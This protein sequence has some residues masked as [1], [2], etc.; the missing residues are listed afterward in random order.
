MTDP[1][2][3]AAD[4]GLDADDFAHMREITD[5]LREDQRFGAE[6]AHNTRDI[7]VNAKDLERHRRKLLAATGNYGT[8]DLEAETFHKLVDM[9][10]KADM[11]VTDFLADLI[12]RAVPVYEVHVADQVLAVGRAKWPSLDAEKVVEKLVVRGAEKL[13]DERKKE[14]RA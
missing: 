12:L 6:I 10:D 5:A 13:G 2:D 7:S 1:D 14:K 8:L 11:P 4:A 9:A 3:T